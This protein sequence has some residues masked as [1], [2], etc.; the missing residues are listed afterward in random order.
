MIYLTTSFKVVKSS[1]FNFI[2][3]NKF[4]FLLRDLDSVK[5]D[6]ITFGLEY[7]C[8][9]YGISK[10]QWGILFENEVKK[11]NFAMNCVLLE[12]DYFKEIFSLYGPKH[13]RQVL[14]LDN[15]KFDEQWE[16]VFDFLA[17]AND[18]IFDFVRLNFKNLILDS[19]LRLYLGL[20]KSK[21]DDT[22][23]NVVLSLTRL[24]KNNFQH[25]EEEIVSFFTL[26]YSENR[27]HKKI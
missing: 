17:I 22:W 27:I 14:Y 13:V 12:L 7:V 4:S 6:F 3:L 21:Y 1:S 5:Q 16:R 25:R 11:H 23:D 9:K 20:G 26:I 24:Y 8:D 2:I 19:S 15:S 10:E 18:L